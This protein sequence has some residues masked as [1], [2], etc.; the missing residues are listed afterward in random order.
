M[1]IDYMN[2]VNSSHALLYTE[3]SSMPY[4]QTQWD[5]FQRQKYL[6]CI[7]HHTGYRSVGSRSILH[8]S[9][10]LLLQELRAITAQSCCTSDR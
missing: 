3:H 4:T 7:F 8:P 6:I 2:A 9:H 5:V 1:G 10:L